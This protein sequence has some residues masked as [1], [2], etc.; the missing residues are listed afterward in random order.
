MSLHYVQVT[1]SRLIAI[2]TSEINNDRIKVQIKMGILFCR[3]KVVHFYDKRKHTYKYF[4]SRVSHTT[5]QRHVSI[6]SVTNIRVS[7]NKNTIRTQIILQKFTT[8]PLNV[9]IKFLTTK[10]L[11][12]TKRQIY[13]FTFLLKYATSGRFLI[14]IM[15]SALYILL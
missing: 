2:R 9:M 15:A 13:N 4:K 1:C 6:A 12:V 10:K 5:L 3:R 7:Y 11:K 8:Q 14:A